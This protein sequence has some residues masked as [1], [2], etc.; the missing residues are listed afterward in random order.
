MNKTLDLLKK[1]RILN[2]LELSFSKTELVTA[3]APHVACQNADCEAHPNWLNQRFSDGAWESAAH[4]LSRKSFLDP[5]LTSAIALLPGIFL[6]LVMS[7][8]KDS[9]PK[10]ILP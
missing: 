10:A 3:A 6:H 5:S 2:S 9:W 8:W 7:E 1:G 4:Q